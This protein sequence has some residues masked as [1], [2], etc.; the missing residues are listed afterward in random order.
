MCVETI[1][2]EPTKNFVD[3]FSMLGGVVRIYKNVI[4]VDDNVHIQEVAE[5]VVHVALKS[6]RSVGETE[7]HDQPFKGAITSSEGG[8][9]FITFGDTNHVIG[10]ADVQ[11]CVNASFSS[12]G[13]EVRDEGQQVAVLLCDFVQSSEIN[14]E[15]KSTVFLFC[16]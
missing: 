13:E 2:A 5:N 10:M 8:F 12:G 1:L 6:S 9:P 16:K 4:Q 7:G 14:A 11:C 3:V 15:V